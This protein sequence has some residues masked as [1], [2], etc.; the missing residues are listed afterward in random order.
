MAAGTCKRS[1]TFRATRHPRRRRTCASRRSKSSRAACC[2]RGIRSLADRVERADYCIQ[3]A[4]FAIGRRGKMSRAMK[5]RLAG[6]STVICFVIAILL[7][8]LWVRGLVVR[9]ELVTHVAGRKLLIG[10]SPHH[11]YVLG[12]PEPVGCTPTGFQSGLR[13]YPS[14]P[15]YWELRY[16]HRPG[17]VLRIGVPYWL[18]LSF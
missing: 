13:Q 10:N 7:A 16:H 12:Y 17:G 6:I 8:V 2:G 15:I 11:V 4:R 5:G 3:M 1:S 9:D 14:R 18:P